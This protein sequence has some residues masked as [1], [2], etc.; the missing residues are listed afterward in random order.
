MLV[1]A[2]SIYAQYEWSIVVPIGE[3]EKA[4]TEP[5]IGFVAPGPRRN[6]VYAV[7]TDTRFFK[8]TLKGI[9]EKAL[10]CEAGDFGGGLHWQNAQTMD[11]LYVIV[12]HNA[13]RPGAVVQFGDRS[14]WTSP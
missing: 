12:G 14:G 13:L 10:A 5:A 2:E 4:T 6:S 7:G 9:E 8:E 11:K 3:M 1:D